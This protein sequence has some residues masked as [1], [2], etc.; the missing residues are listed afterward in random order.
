[1][2]S[3]EISA[4]SVRSV[5]SVYSSIQEFSSKIRKFINIGNSSSILLYSLIE[6]ILDLSKIEAGTFFIN[7]SSFS[8]VDLIDEIMQV[9]QFQWI[10]KKIELHAKIDPRIKNIKIDSDRWRIKQVLLNLMSNAIKFTFEGGILITACIT[11]NN[12]FIQ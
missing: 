9:F 4:T 10:Q 12:D 6:D 5:N 2:K 1:M 7:I 3:T 8:V 11:E